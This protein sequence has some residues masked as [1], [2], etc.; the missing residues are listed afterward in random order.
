V[1]NLF[2]KTTP[3]LAPLMRRVLIVD[4][5]PGNARLLGEIVREIASPEIWSATT[6]AKALKLAAKVEPDLIFCTLADAGVEGTA[7]TRSLRRS[8]LACRKAPVVLTTAHGAA[9]DILAGRDAGAHEF[10]RRPFIRK[11]VAR[12]LEAA[13]LVPRGWVEALDYVGPDRRRF[14]SAEFEGPLKRLADRDAPGQS[15]RV[16]EALKIVRSALA[17]LER[18][19][20]QAL[21][22]LTAQTAELE[23]AAAAIP[24]ARL[25]QAAAELHGYLS[26]AARAG[27]AVDPAECRERAAGLL[28]Y[29]GRETRAAA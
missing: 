16:A 8:D 13:M 14:N 1:F 27:A 26:D 7:F 2:A 4:P 6:N 19:P 25:A 17:A 11:D 15:V 3:R 29:A 28:A 23:L 9:A 21:R 22:A 24:D 12:R 18:D 20:R 5:Q 10:L